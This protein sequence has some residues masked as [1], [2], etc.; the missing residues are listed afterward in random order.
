MK[1]YFFNVFNGERSEHIDD[2]G[3]MLPHRAAAWE[4]ATRYAA[5]SL[6]DLDGRLRPGEDWRLEVLRENE[7]RVFQIVVHGTDFN[8]EHTGDER[9]G[10]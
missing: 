9:D 10:S 3:E 7:T 5:E 6:R 1:R 2:V 8:Q 4:M